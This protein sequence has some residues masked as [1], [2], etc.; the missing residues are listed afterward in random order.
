M[1]PKHYLLLRRMNLVRRALR[2]TAPSAATVTQIA[3]Q[4]G[5]WHFGRFAG[6]YQ[7]LFGE[8]PIATLNR[9]PA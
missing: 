8:M 4:F 5:F 3:G 1:G 6:G 9:P 2:E 7:S